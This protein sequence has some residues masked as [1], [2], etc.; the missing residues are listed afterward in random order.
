LSRLSDALGLVLL[1][2]AGVR[3]IWR[4]EPVAFCSVQGHQRLSR[5]DLH[6]EAGFRCAAGV[7]ADLGRPTPLP[8]ESRRGLLSGLQPG[9]RNSGQSEPQLDIPRNCTSV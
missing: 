2:G 4:I 3:S 1:G 8:Q 7:P 6:T 5:S 9:R